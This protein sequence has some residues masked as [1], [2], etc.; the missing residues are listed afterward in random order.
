MLEVVDS[1]GSLSGVSATVL[2]NRV[3][4]YVPAID[5]AVHLVAD[6]IRRA[7]RIWSPDGSPA[8]EMAV[9][10]DSQ[11][12]PLIL[13]DTDIVFEL[14]SP[15]VVLDSPVRISVHD[16]PQ[17]IGYRD[18]TRNAEW[19]GRESRAFSNPFAAAGDLLQT[20]CFIVGATRWGLRPLAAVYWWE[21]AWEQLRDVAFFQEW[22]VDRLWTELVVEA[23]EAGRAGRLDWTVP[24][25]TRDERRAV[26]GLTVADFAA[27]EPDLQAVGLD[28]EF[29]AAWRR[30]IPFTPTTF[31]ETLLRGLRAGRAAVTLY[32]DGGGAID[33][34]VPVASPRHALLQ[35]RFVIPEGVMWIDEVRVANGR[36]TGLF[37]R[38]LCNCEQLADRIGLQRI[39]VFATGDGAIAFSG[40]AAF[41]RDPELYQALRDRNP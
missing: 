8:V 17:L 31:R 19:L 4:V 39:E 9:A 6:D 2:E 20:R 5:D 7:T 12:W 10:G 22:R 29:V 24:P 40:L 30:W 13:T 27:E 1:L 36:G 25:S 28:D 26:A 38:L 41:P 35:L 14:A 18:V 33:I 32:P 3:R 34:R 16:M 21:R 11:L 37:Q 15:D 23:E